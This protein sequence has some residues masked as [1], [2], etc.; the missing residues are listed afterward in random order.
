MKREVE[1][2]AMVYK[3][4]K[5]LDFIVDQLGNFQPDYSDIKYYYRIVANDPTPAVIASLEAKFK[6][7]DIT[8]F[9]IYNDLNPDDYYL[10][11]VYRA[12]NYCVNSS[13][14]ENVILVN[15]DMAFSDGWI[16]A[17]F[18]HHDGINIPCSRLVESGKLE[19]GCGIPNR[20]WATAMNFG[21]HPDNFNS[22]SWL[23]SANISR[24]DRAEPNGLYMPCLF[25]VERFKEAGGYPEG[26]IYDTGIGKFGD[27]FIKSGD[28]YF[29]HDVLEKQ[30]N[31]KHITVFD[32]L[33]YHMQEGE[34]DE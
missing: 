9:D 17:L 20:G 18:Q 27:R 14:R 2:I 22:A 31:M 6:C 11:R 28:D 26:N 24:V 33:V 4:T 7:G 13:K 34:K 15:S 3:S 19:V 32:S 30:F 12:W 1:V 5:F 21:T 23:G 10:N 8:A 25:N 16:E 29:F